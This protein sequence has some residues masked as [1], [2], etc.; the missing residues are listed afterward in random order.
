VLALQDLQ[1]PQAQEQVTHLQWLLLKEVMEE[2]DNTFQETGQ[3][4]V[5]AV[6][7]EA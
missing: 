5:A 3:L 6:E 2:Q 4:V 7:Q 1:E